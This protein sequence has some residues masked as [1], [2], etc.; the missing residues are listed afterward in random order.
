MVD[1]LQQNISTTVIYQAGTSFKSV[2]LAVLICITQS[3][4]LGTQKDN[5][6]STDDCSVQ[7]TSV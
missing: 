3:T 6:T 7:C 5:I 1:L 4:V 2:Q